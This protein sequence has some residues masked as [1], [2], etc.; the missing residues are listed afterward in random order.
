MSSANIHNLARDGKEKELAEEIRKQPHR[1]D[2]RDSVSLLNYGDMPT[3]H[4]F[5]FRTMCV[6]WSN[7][8]K[9]NRVE[10]IKFHSLRI[11]TTFFSR[12]LPKRQIFR[13]DF[14]LSET[15]CKDLR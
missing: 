9:S 10:S 5:F 11:S 2:E 14:E 4:V 7:R 15:K 1:V 3:L 12:R 13:L 8:I 6:Y